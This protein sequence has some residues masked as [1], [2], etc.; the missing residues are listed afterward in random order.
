MCDKKKDWT[1]TCG[2]VCSRDWPTLLCSHW[3]KKEVKPWA[4]QYQHV[5]CFGPPRRKKF[6]VFGL[7]WWFEI[8]F[9]SLHIIAVKLRFRHFGINIIFL[10]CKK[11]YCVQ[12]S[13]QNT[14]WFKRWRGGGEDTKQ[15]AKMWHVPVVH[16]VGNYIVHFSLVTGVCQDSLPAS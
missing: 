7:L 10:N 5:S 6:A 12:I 16:M 9:D 14:P 3:K 15:G 1:L 13:L 4:N 11:E 8:T 2:L